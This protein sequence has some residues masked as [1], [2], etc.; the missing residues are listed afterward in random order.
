MVLSRPDLLDY[1]ESGRLRFD[2]A[3]PADSVEQV[4]VD[5]RLGRHFARFRRAG[6]GFL[7]SVRVHPSLWQADVWERQ[8]ADAFTLEPG[9]LVLAQTLEVVTI[10]NDVMG[11]VEGR[12][13]WARVGVSVHISAPKIDP[14]FHGII[15]LEMA[16]LGPMPV[17]LTA[18]EDRPCQLILLRLTTPCP[19]SEQ[20]GTRATHFF[21]GQRAPIPPRQAS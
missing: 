12:S 19:E 11:L 8:E 17:L 14:G 5:L 1:I 2:P 6:L 15:T 3:V 13:T 16:N 20:Y 10:P 18:G 9:E 4:S 21:Q 7:G